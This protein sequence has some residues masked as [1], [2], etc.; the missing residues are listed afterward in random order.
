MHAGCDHVQSLHGACNAGVAAVS[1]FDRAH[2]RCYWVKGASAALLNYLGHTVTAMSYLAGSTQLTLHLQSPAAAAAA[3]HAAEE[4][5]AAM[6]A[7]ATGRRT[8][9]VMV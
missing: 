3:Q 8:R 1:S 4:A 9:C 6:E 7:A 5:A 2:G